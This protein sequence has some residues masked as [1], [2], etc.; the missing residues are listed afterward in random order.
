V[1]KISPKEV[2]LEKKLF[3]DEKLKEI[4]EK[5]YSLNIYFFESNNNPTTILEE[6]FEVKNLE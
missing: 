6:H 3:G 1:Y 2:I 4:L 5:K